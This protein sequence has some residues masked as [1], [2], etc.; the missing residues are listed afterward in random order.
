MKTGTTSANVHSLLSE[1]TP[2]YLTILSIPIILSETRSPHS[3]TE[4][5]RLTG[6]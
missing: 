1:A 6:R 5:P 3:V 2:P 4:S